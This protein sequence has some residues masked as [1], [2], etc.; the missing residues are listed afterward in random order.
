M[1]ALKAHIISFI[2]LAAVAIF[3]SDV[4]KATKS[5]WY[6]CIRP[7]ITPPNIVFPIVWTILYI[8]IALA[9]AQTFMIKGEANK[10]KK[11]ALLWFFSINLVLNVVWSL[12]Y[13][14]LKEVTAAFI[15]IIG[16]ILS[17]L[18]I[19]KYTRDILPPWV[20]WILVPYTCWLF[21]AGVLN[22]ISMTNVKRCV[23]YI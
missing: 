7:S 18:M 11:A 23:K 5:R 16:L 14:G 21:F 6:Q 12:M 8:L 1:D 15:V 4:M 13:F 10:N 20:F 3:P 22:I 19:M 9:L 17:Q 2:I